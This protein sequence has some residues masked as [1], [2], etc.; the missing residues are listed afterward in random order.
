MCVAVDPWWQESRRDS[1][2]DVQ[3]RFLCGP[4]PS[5]GR[6]AAPSTPAEAAG[7][8]PYDEIRCR[9]DDGL[10]VPFGGMT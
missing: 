10:A 9:I 1:S 8:L 6:G 5:C 2:D 3:Q 4:R 7:I